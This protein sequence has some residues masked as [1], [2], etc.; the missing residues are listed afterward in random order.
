MI[1]NID[2]TFYSHFIDCA[3]SKRDPM[4]N[5]EYVK[6]CVTNHNTITVNRVLIRKESAPCVAR[7]YWIPP[8]T[9]NPT[10]KPKHCIYLYLK[11]FLSLHS[12]FIYEKKKK[13][14][15]KCTRL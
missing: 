15:R 11:P 4:V 8:S 13:K 1:C 2:H 9:V 5:V 14:V 3:D 7:S 10:C 6:A 12:S